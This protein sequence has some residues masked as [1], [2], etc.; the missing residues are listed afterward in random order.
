MSSGRSEAARRMWLTTAPPFCASPAMSIIREQFLPLQVGG[1]A[2][3]AR[4]WSPRRCRRPRSRRCSVGMRFEGRHRRLPAGRPRE[5]CC[6]A[7]LLRQRVSS[8]GPSRRRAP[9]RRTG[10]E[11]VHAGEILVASDDWSMACACARI[12]FPRVRLRNAVGLSPNSRRSPHR[13]DRVDEEPRFGGHRGRGLR[14][15]RRR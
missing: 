6:G 11:A 14:L 15:R 5:V 3:A 13:P 8:C 10:A 12:R 4:R 7:R 2:E 1:H 9:S